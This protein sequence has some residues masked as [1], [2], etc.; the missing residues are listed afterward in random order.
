MAKEQKTPFI[1]HVFVC[2]HSRGGARKACADN[3]SP[4]T[5]DKLKQLVSEKGWK[6]KV[7]VSP[8]GCLG[9][10]DEGPNVMIYPQG[11]W[12]SEVSSEDAGQIVAR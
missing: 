5:L 7:K 10:C 12:F 1:C 6:G 3:N 9:P 8:S 4:V 11:V 2:T